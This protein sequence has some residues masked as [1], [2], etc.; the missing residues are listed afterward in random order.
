MGDIRAPLVHPSGLVHFFLTSIAPRSTFL[1]STIRFSKKG[2]TS[3]RKK[4]LWS[5]SVALIIAEAVREEFP[6]RKYSSDMFGIFTRLYVPNI[7][8]SGPCGRQS[9]MLEAWERGWERG[10]ERLW[11]NCSVVSSVELEMVVY[12]ELWAGADRLRTGRPDVEKV[13]LTVRH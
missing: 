2:W 12:C 8:S 13:F 9:L 10:W 3:S 11:D 5:R 6:D 7:W 4:G 1:L